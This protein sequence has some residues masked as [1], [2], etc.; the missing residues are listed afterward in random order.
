MVVQTQG[1]NYN[2]SNAEK[3][4]VQN[5]YTDIPSSYFDNYNSKSQHLWLLHM[6]S[7]GIPIWFYIMGINHE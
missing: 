1:I 5:T 3:N 6:S 2:E 7:R 4:S